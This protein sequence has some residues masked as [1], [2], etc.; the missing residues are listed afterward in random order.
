MSD[1]NLARQ[2]RQDQRG[3]SSVDDP[4]RSTCSAKNAK[5]A[6]YHDTVQRGRFTV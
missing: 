6:E 2:H 5:S 1:A 4:P 3:G